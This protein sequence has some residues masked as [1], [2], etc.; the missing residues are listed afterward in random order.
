[1]ST[2]AAHYAEAE[3]LI[4]EVNATPANQLVQAVDVAAAALAKAQVH[5]TLALAAAVYRQ[6]A[7]AHGVDNSGYGR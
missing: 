5:A 6:S 4:A 1:M 3:R 7:L 2:G